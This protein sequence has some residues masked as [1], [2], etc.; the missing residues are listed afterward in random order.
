MTVASLLFLVCSFVLV[1]FAVQDDA[2]RR[3]PHLG[4]VSAVSAMG[5]KFIQ[6]RQKDAFKPGGQIECEVCINFMNQAVNA[7]IQIIGQGGIGG[8]CSAVCGELRMCSFVHF[9]LLFLTVSTIVDGTNLLCSVRI[10]GH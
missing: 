2:L 4:T 8:G 7:L 9:S 3:R 5:Q 10:R 1:A 6:V